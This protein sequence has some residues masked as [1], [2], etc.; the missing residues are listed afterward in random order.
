MSAQTR[1]SELEQEKAALESKYARCNPLTEA[2]SAKQKAETA[3]RVA[4][5]NLTALQQARGML[6]PILCILRLMFSPTTRF[7]FI[8]TMNLNLSLGVLKFL[9]CFRLKSSYFVLNFFV[10]D[11]CFL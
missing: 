11:K 9:A 6:G 4:Q 8:R 2:L 1:I 10:N 3:A 5:E 7:F